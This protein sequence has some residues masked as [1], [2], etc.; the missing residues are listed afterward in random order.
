MTDRVSDGVSDGISDEAGDGVGGL[1]TRLETQRALLQTWVTSPEA[2]ALAVML[3]RRRRLTSSPDE[4]ISEAWLRIMRS[5]RT[6]TEP[7]PE[8]NTLVDAQRYCARVIDNLCRDAGRRTMR[9]RESSLDVLTEERNLQ[10]V[11]ATDPIDEAN[12]RLMVERL[13]MVLGAHVD[14][15]FRCPGCPTHVAAATAFEVLHMVLAGVDGEQRGRNWWDQLLYTALDRVD[16]PEGD[17]SVSAAAT[18]QRK[19]RCGRCVTELLNAALS[20]S[21]GGSP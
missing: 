13:L 7:L 21:I 3:V 10:P 16:P 1:A 19:S 14:K 6:R 20:S 18:A 17:R 11:T 12:N 9:S 4:L 8:M 5:F 2:R 15:G